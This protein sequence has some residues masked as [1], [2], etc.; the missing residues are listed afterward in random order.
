MA[1][2]STVSAGT[3]RRVDLVVDLAVTTA[4]GAVALM[5]GKIASILAV[6]RSRVWG[7]SGRI[8][9]PVR[10]DGKSPCPSGPWGDNVSWS[11]TWDGDP[12]HCATNR[13]LTQPP[14]VRVDVPCESL[15]SLFWP[16]IFADV[17][18]TL[19]QALSGRPRAVDSWQTKAQWTRDVMTLVSMAYEA[20]NTQPI[21][22]YPAQW[23]TREAWKT[24]EGTPTAPADI[25]LRNWGVPT[26]HWTYDENPA[27]RF[28]YE[29]RPGSMQRT[30]GGS[31]PRRIHQWVVNAK[32]LKMAAEGVAPSEIAAYGSQQLLCGR[33]LVLDDTGAVRRFSLP[34]ASWKPSMMGGASSDQG[35]GGFMFMADNSATNKALTAADFDPWSTRGFD[36]RW[37]SRRPA[38]PRDMA[39]G[40]TTETMYQYFKDRSLAVFMEALYRSTDRDASL[41]IP[42]VAQQLP[43]GAR[44]ATVLVGGWGPSAK[45]Y[46]ELAVQ[47]AEEIVGLDYWD[48]VTNSLLFYLVNHA[49]YYKRLHGAGAISI[50]AED[51]GNMADAVRSAK[52]QMLALPAQMGAQIMSLAGGPIVGAIAGIVGDIQAGIM[53]FASQLYSHPDLPKSL[54][55]RLPLDETCEFDTSDQIGRAA[56]IV[57]DRARPPPPP[58]PAGQGKPSWWLIGGGVAA[59]VGLGYLLL[60][61]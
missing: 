39:A 23:A 4:P 27:C 47:W 3:A 50:S 59:A 34:E 28:S 56:G 14:I 44:G 45:Y 12:V 58:A 53:E 2:V 55:R 32:R 43:Y 22:F 24:Y 25:A 30:S 17:Q 51:L 61:D 54:L 31:L 41:Y 10:L 11:K 38:I 33:S 9:L 46:T 18:R 13:D 37:S 1:V 20:T 7:A 42:Y 5:N 52:Q 8:P 21:F 40:R 29:G 36:S 16:D 49:T 57:V 19:R 35:S 15:E 48:F 26:T 6:I 60:S